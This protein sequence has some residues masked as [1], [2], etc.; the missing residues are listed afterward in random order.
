MRRDHYALYAEGRIGTLRLPNRLVRS[1]TWDPVILGRRAL[2]DEVLALYCGLANGEVGLIIT[3]GLTVY[4]A[5]LCG[6]I[7]MLAG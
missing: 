6:Y 2:T 7:A 3:G 1:A 5:D 4:P